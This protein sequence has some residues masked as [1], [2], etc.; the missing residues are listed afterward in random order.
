MASEEGTL[1]LSKRALKTMRPRRRKMS[2]ST[3][4][5]FGNRKTVR[6]YRKACKEECQL[7]AKEEDRKRGKRKRKKEEKRITD[8]EVF[9]A[10]D[11]LSPKLLH[12]FRV[13]SSG[14]LGSF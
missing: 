8:L 10:I 11:K 6:L 12:Q 1:L 13:R 4:F 7:E 5:R 9:V 3:T 2:R 14:I